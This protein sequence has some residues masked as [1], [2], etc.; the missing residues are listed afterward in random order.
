MNDFRVSRKKSEE[1]KSKKDKEIHGD[2]DNN[3]A[4]LTII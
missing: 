4:K 1:K 3:N 2:N